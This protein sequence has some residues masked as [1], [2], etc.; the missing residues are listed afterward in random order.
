MGKGRLY[1]MPNVL[2]IKDEPAREIA[3]FDLLLVRPD[4]HVA[5]RG[6]QLAD[7]TG[8]IAAV[9]TSRLPADIVH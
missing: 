7:E 6:N 1:H 8:T 4:L 9:A 2:D 3:A 5:W